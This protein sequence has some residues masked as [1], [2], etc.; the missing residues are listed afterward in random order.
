MKRDLSLLGGNEFDIVIIGGGIYGVNAAWDAALR[1]LSVALIEKNDF[2]AA[3]SSNSLKIIHGGLRYLQHADFKRMRQSIV[4]RRTLMRIAPH[5][6]HPLRCVMPTYGHGLKGKEVMAVALMINDIVGFDRNAHLEPHKHLPRG[7]V[8]SKEACIEMIPGV[9]QSGLTGGALWYDCQVS[10]S[11]RLLM[12]VLRSAVQAGAVAANYVEMADFVKKGNRVTGVRAKDTLTGETFEIGAKLVIN[13]AGPW[14]NS[15]MSHLNGDA[16]REKVKLSAAMNLVVRKKLF[17]DIAVGVYSKS[18]FNDEDAVLNKGSRLLFITPWNE[19]S[20]IGTTHVHYE[21]EPGNFKIKESDIL[22]F[23]QEVNEAYPAAE[24]TRE[25][26]VFHYGGLLPIDSVNQ[27]T[28]DV[29]LRKSYQIIDHERTSGLEG[30]L[31]VV[32][33]KYTTA[34]DVAQKTID[35]AVQKL[36]RQR[37]PSVTGNTPVFGGAIACLGDFL[38]SAKKEAAAGLDSDSIEHLVQN[39]GSE[40][41]GVAKYADERPEWRQPIGDS[42]VLQAEVAHAVREEMALKLADVVRRRTTLGSGAY[43]GDEA[44]QACARLMAD[45]LG[46]DQARIGRE[47]EETKAIYATE[48]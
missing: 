32:S 21:G 1:G 40:Y 17:D 20:L 18:N 10:N 39:Y 25:D 3:T 26:V 29:K 8:I 9:E 16:P 24:L 28:G 45:E 11:E 13:N 7:H 46:W 2:G 31:S 14:T 23:L 30:L 37:I 5:L 19:Y 6:V 38:A 27:K 44:V 41:A 33:V 48:N 42:K 47:I 22:E 15:V 34:R 43:P 12:S 35:H 36:G 4:E